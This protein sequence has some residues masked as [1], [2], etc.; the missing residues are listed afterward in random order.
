[1]HCQAKCC[2]LRNIYLDNATAKQV[3]ENYL[4]A[5]KRATANNEIFEQIV[6]IGMLL[7]D[8]INRIATVMPKLLFVCVYI[9]PSRE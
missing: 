8:S 6:E 7:I 5:F 3:I 1:M 2:M 9:C 4:H